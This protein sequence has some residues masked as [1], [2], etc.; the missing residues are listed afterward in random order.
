MGCLLM[1]S[2]GRLASYYPPR[3]LHFGE[4]LYESLK[5]L[6]P[7]QV[8]SLG[9]AVFLCFVEA[10]VKH[11]KPIAALH[12]IWLRVVQLLSQKD[13]Y[14]NVQPEP[15]PSQEEHLPAL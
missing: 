14:S 4:V 3:S 2:W 12:L 13:T 11:V 10:A 15:G 6:V 9:F 5:P 1:L 7:S 8:S